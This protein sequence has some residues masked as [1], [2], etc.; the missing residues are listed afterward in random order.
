[1]IFATNI[2]Y[3][4]DLKYLNGVKSMSVQNLDPEQVEL[5]MSEPL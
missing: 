2:Y 5:T 3:C 4:V 1:M